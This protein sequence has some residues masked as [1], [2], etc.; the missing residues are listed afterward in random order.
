[1]IAAIFSFIGVIV[2]AFLQYYFTR[3]LEGQRHH[4]EL[5]TAAYTDYLKC[6]SEHANLRVHRQTQEGRELG[7][8]TAD[9]KCRIC[10]YGSS[11]VISAFADFERLGATMNTS[12]Q[13]AAFTRMVSIMRCDSMRDGRIDSA[14]LQTVLLGYLPNS[15]DASERQ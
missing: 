15:G 1:M 5:R 2:G 12:E 3:H 13:C 6:V 4:R 9:A 8:R 11:Q 14:E 7:Q 10:L